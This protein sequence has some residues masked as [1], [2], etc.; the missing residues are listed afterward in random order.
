[1]MTQNEREKYRR[2]LQLFKKSKQWQKQD[3]YLHDKLLQHPDDYEILSDISRLKYELGEPSEALKYARQA[4]S[5]APHDYSVLFNYALSL[6]GNDEYNAAFDAFND[7]IQGGMQAIS[8]STCRRDTRHSKSIY[9]DSYLLAGLC[10]LYRNDFDQAERLLIEHINL[11][12]RGIYSG[13]SLA[14]VKKS[15]SQA[16]NHIYQEQY[17]GQIEGSKFQQLYDSVRKNENETERYTFL[18]SYFLKYPE[19]YFILVELSSVANNL[20]YHEEALKYSEKAM[21]IEPAD[22]L[23]KYTYSIAL[24]GVGENESAAKILKQILRSDINDIAYGEHGEGMKYAKQI[25]NDSIYLLGVS[26]LNRK[27]KDLAKQ[28]F[29]KH[30]AN[31]Q[32]GIPSDFNKVTV[33]KKLQEV[34]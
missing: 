15:L 9:I 14:S 17:M 4:R 16:I 29:K 23:V 21:Q 1:M 26:Y 7:I 6:F 20:D 18:K 28:Y 11:R 2:D 10:R 19:D 22:Y 24:I 12:R 8:D 32:K 5:I 3:S 25:M 13:T 34:I 33:I 30:L 27:R 31:R